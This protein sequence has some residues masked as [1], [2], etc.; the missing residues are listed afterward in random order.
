[1]SRFLPLTIRLVDGTTIVVSSIG[2]AQKA[3]TGR[4]RNKEAKTYKEAVRLLEAAEDGVCKP[5]VAFEAFEVAAHEQG[6]LQP[7]KPCSALAM[8]D[9]LTSPVAPLQAG[10]R[11][12]NEF[13]SNVV[14]KTSLPR[15]NGATT[16]WTKSPR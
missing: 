2:D 7:A 11:R 8:L 6:L 12:Q 10:A 9:D 4:W 1:M 3:L 5:A 16:R 13:R 14:Q 15:R